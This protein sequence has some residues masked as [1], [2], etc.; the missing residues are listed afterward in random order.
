MA[1][2]KVT[3]QLSTAEAAYIAGLVDGEG[4]VT[5]TRKHRNENRH[6]GLTISS[7]EMQLLQF[8]VDAAGVGK[9]SNKKA[10]KP[11]HSH[12]YAYGVY[13]RQALQLIEQIY[14]HLL[15]YKAERCALVLCDYLRLTPRNGKYTSE[16]IEERKRFECQF[17]SIKP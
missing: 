1:A 7:T 3:R 12:S 10:S 9:I 16:M 6:L 14:P 17:L 13:N 2:Y 4:S 8:V 5:L 15:S 11:N